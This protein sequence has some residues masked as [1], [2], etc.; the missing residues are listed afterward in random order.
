MPE[1]SGKKPRTSGRSSKPKKEEVKDKKSPKLKEDK[2]ET[3]KKVT[4]T[5]EHG[6]KEGKKEQPP[7][8]QK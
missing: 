4:P 6:D 3:D 2:E 8:Q 1:A 5:R 7:P